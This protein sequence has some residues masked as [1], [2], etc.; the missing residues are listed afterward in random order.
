[1]R[2]INRHPVESDERSSHESTST[3]EDWLNWIGD[4]DIPNDSEDDCAG[5]VKSD[6]EQEDSIDDPECPEQRDLSTALTDPGLIRL[7]LKLERQDE[8]VLV[9]GNA[10]ETRRIHSVKKK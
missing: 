3:T 1:M 2:I 4:L 6:I 5:D 8:T 9:M 10:I 7:T